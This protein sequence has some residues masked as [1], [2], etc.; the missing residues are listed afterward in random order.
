MATAVNTTMTGNQEIDGLLQGSKWSGTITYS[1]PDDRGDYPSSYSVAAEPGRNMKPVS[2]S[3]QAAVIDA[4]NLVMKY[5]NATLEYAGTDGADIMVASAALDRMPG[6]GAYTYYPNMLY[7]REISN[8]FRDQGGDMWVNTGSAHDMTNASPGNVAYYTA[9]HEFG[10]ALGLKH[11]GLDSASA[12]GEIPLPAPHENME[13]SVM[14]YRSYEGGP[15]SSLSNDYPTTYMA[16]DILALQT[17]YGANYTTNNG[18][19]R[20]TWDPAG[21]K[22]FETLW[23]GGGNDTYDLS[24]YSTNLSIDLR[25]G[26][27]SLFSTTQQA[28]LL[29]GHYAAGNIYNAYL[30]QDNKASLIEN[31]IGGAGGDALRGNEAANT[32]QGGAG[33]DLLDGDTGNDTL[34]GGAGDD[35]FVFRADAT[36]AGTDVIRSFGDSAGDEDVIVLSDVAANVTAADFAAW[37]AG[38]VTQVG[39]DVEIRFGDDRVVLSNVQESALDYADFRFGA[40]LLFNGTSADDALWGSSGNDTLN[41]LA[42]NDALS[43]SDGNDTLNGGDGDDALNGG[44]GNDALDGGAGVDTLDGGDGDDTLRTGGTEMDTIRGGN[45][46]DTLSLTSDATIDWSLLNYSSGIEH[47]VGNGFGITVMNQGTV[48]SLRDANFSIDGLAFIKLGTPDTSFMPMFYGSDDDDTFYGSDGADGIDASNG[49]DSLYGGDGDDRLYGGNGNDVLDG[50]NGSDGF[51]GGAGNDIFIFRADPTGAASDIIGVFGDSADNEDIIDLSDALSVT[52]ANFDAWKSSAVVQSG[53]DAEIRFGDDSV[54]LLAVSADNLDYS[55]FLFAADV[56]INGTAGDDILNGT[57]DNDTINGLA[58][59]DTLSGGDGD[60]TLNGGSGQ[61][62]LYGG[63]GNDTLNAGG[64]MFARDTL[65]GGTGNDVLNSSVGRST[66][67]FNADP[68][69]AAVDTINNFGDST[70]DVLFHDDLIDLSAVFGDV[71]LADFTAWKNSHVTQSGANVNISLGDDT[72]VLTNYSASRLDYTDFTWFNKP[73]M[74]SGAGGD[75]AHRLVGDS[76]N[77][78]LTGNA[79]NNTLWGFA[80]DDTL[81]GGAGNDLLAGDE[82]HDTLDGG[83]G[84]DIFLIADYARVGVDT[85]RGGEGTDILYFTGPVTIPQLE[86]AW[87]D[88]NSGIECIAGNNREI[89][90]TDASE[91][92][93]FSGLSILTDI[94]ALRSKGGDDTLIGSDNSD[95]FIGDDGNDTL[96]GGAG[97]DSL[98]GGNGDDNINGGDGDDRVFGDYG[99]DS[100]SGGNGDDYVSGLDG[101]DRL[102]GGMGSDSLSGDAGDDVFICNADSSGAITDYISDFG[103]SAGNE[104]VID[105][106]T[107]VSGVNAANFDGWKNDNVTQQGDKVDI[108]FGDDHVMLYNTQ[109]SLLDYS[110]FVFAV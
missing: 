102:D 2:S 55:D 48:A 12:P 44:S 66:F 103:D 47:L 54:V 88:P 62:T 49:N 81:Y 30:Y 8:G 46:D 68:T 56:S 45:G 77:D 100:V 53:A 73:N 40:D 18:D 91:I 34:E 25:P 110:D 14:S 109:A 1:F 95:L 42:G 19:T 50:G 26:A 24:N 72:V 4:A 31:A 93:D 22:I 94:H 28:D 37:K 41:G 35:V 97:N 51:N 101:N 15:A 58:G 16:N 23:D 83:A 27:A 92:V 71:T 80:G 85:I 63:N 6:T 32:L 60:D 59:N 36:G 67:V 33:N 105:L 90:G 3:F 10:H 61:D 76:A 65:D 70:H 75:A 78:T 11:S 57:A 52:A 107:V 108:R 21:G 9:V 38:N 87:L 29:D 5:T 39:T 99:N 7:P 106:S 96:Y 20:Y 82:G 89:F 17:L 69:G 74:P 43:G 98:V 104:D 84:N 13:Y 64:N 86:Q 79:D